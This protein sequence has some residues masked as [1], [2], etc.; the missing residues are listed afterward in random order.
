MRRRP[1]RMMHSPNFGPF[2]STDAGGRP[3]S[4]T[5]GIGQTDGVPAV[6]IPGL[7]DFMS[8][9][10]GMAIPTIFTPW[11]KLQ[12]STTPFGWSVAPLAGPADTN[13]VAFEM[14]E[15]ADLLDSLGFVQPAFLAFLS[16]QPLSPPQVSAALAGTPYARSG[17]GIAVYA[18]ADGAEVPKEYF[19]YWAGLRDPG[20]QTGGAGSVAVAAQSVG[21]TLVFAQQVPRESTDQRPPPTASAYDAAVAQYPQVF[22]P[23]QYSGAQPP[24][25]PAAPPGSAPSASAS[26]V[27]P[28][29]IGVASGVLGVLI[30]RSA[31][32]RSQ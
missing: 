5:H 12:Q 3:S 19:L 21:A 17:D 25:P 15:V 4:A 30:G 28:A 14:A 9:A 20:D 6:N 24:P 31:T 23:K 16:S 10:Q 13:I 27:A 18:Q 22:P 2:F 7:E 1:K 29:L 26:F 8:T 11:G 32:R